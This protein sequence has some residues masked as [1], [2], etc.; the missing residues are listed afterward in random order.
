MTS[1]CKRILLLMLIL[2]VTL[3][4]IYVQ[5]IQS[6]SYSTETSQYAINTNVV[7]VLLGIDDLIDV[8]DTLVRDNYVIVLDPNLEL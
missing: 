8:I 4:P 2:L 3:A 1:T 5:S 6:H 7:V